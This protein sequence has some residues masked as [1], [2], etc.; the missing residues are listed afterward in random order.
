MRVALKVLLSF[1][2]LAV[3]L[4]G[5]QLAVAVN[6]ALDCSAIGKS[7]APCPV[8]GVDLQPVL[9]FFD[10]WGMLLW[11]PA[12]LVSGLLLGQVLAP[13]LPRPFGTAPRKDPR[14]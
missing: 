1:A 11:I 6:D 4:G 2:P 13:V 9:S 10:W 12:L 7:P 3:T 5:W 14:D 8:G